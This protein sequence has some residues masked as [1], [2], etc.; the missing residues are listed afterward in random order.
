MRCSTPTAACAATD[1]SRAPALL[2]S[3]R[4]GAG[5]AWGGLSSGTEACCRTRAATVLNSAGACMGPGPVLVDT[6]TL[7]RSALPRIAARVSVPS[8]D[9][10][11]LDASVVH[12]GLGSFARAHLCAYLDQL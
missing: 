12:L 9:A 11:D 7:C 5:R 4:G 2:I 1:P 6:P 8:Y 10:A 3:P